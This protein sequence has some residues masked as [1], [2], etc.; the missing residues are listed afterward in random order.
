MASAPIANAARSQIFYF[1]ITTFS[2]RD[3]AEVMVCV[4]VIPEAVFDLNQVF[5]RPESLRL[6]VKGWP[7]FWKETPCVMGSLTPLLLDWA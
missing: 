7:E 4:C 5:T 2:L 1:A 6:A 3:Y